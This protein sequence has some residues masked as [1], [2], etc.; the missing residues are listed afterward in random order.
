MTTPQFGPWATPPRPVKT[1]SKRRRFFFVIWFSVFAFISIAAVIGWGI[2]WDRFGPFVPNRER[3]ELDVQGGVWADGV[4]YPRASVRADDRWYV[5][6]DVVQKAVDPTIAWAADTEEVIVVQDPRVIVA[7]AEGVALNPLA[8]A[9]PLDEDAKPLEGLSLRFPVF[10]Q[11]GRPYLETTLL[12][13]LYSVTVEEPKGD[14]AL[15]LWTD[16]A[17]RVAGEVVDQAARPERIYRLRR[18]PS[19]RAPYIDE[20]APGSALVILDEHNGWYRVVDAYGREGFVPKEGVI[21]RGARVVRAGDDDADRP[22]RVADGE[23]ARDGRAAKGRRVLSDPTWRPVGMRTML[24]WQ[25]ITTRTPAPSSLEVLPEVDVLAP[26]WFELAAPDGTWT[27]RAAVDYVRFFHEQGKRVYAV[28]TNGFDPDLTHAFLND[29]Q[30]VST[31]IAALLRYID[32]YALDGLNIDFENVYLKDRD[33]LT[34]FVRELSAY[35]HAMGK[36]VS[37]DVTVKSS[38]ENYSRVYDRRAFG[39]AVDYVALMAYDEHWATSPVAGP[40]ASLPWVE[41]GVQTLLE[42]VP[43][44]KVLLGVPFYVRLWKETKGEDGRVNVTQRAISMDAAE[45]WLAERGLTPVWDEASG[46]RY[47][48]WTDPQDG[49]RYRLWLEDETSLQARAELVRKYRLAGLAAWRLG[50]ERDGAWMA[51]SEVV[52]RP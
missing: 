31:G 21:L 44:H 15:W 30:A 45:R 43:A 8:D 51:L 39:E 9:A 42:E 11:E 41:K 35:V 16:G 32:I 52:R 17:V 47:A 26:T 34:H 14:G 1:A 27:N 6:L 24:A 3:T 25:L 48:E 49:A 12:E 10:V 4:F 22:D 50:L 36:V 18:E 37:I 40:V 20:L 29:R 7:G 33:K 2:A 38:N 28:V 13:R 19:F 5:A 46:Q 23:R